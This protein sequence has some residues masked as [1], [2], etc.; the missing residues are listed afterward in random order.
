M[1]D[2]QTRL[3]TESLTDEKRAELT[4]AYH[5]ASQSVCTLWYVPG[6]LSGLASVSVLVVVDVSEH[7][8][9][10]SEFRRCVAPTCQG[11]PA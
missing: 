5:C 11:G 4:A 8:Q 9:Y 10:R 3:G 7:V 1:E 2:M 6:G